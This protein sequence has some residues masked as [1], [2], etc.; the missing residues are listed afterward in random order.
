M[1]NVLH[2]RLVF[3]DICYFTFLVSLMAFSVPWKCRDCN[4]G[5]ISSLYS[6][7]CL[8]CFLVATMPKAQWDRERNMDTI[9]EISLA[10]GEPLFLYSENQ[11][12]PKKQHSCPLCW[13]V[14]SRVTNTHQPVAFKLS[15]KHD[16]LWYIAFRL[17]L[18]AAPIFWH[19]LVSI[20]LYPNTLE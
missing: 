20:T 13:L 6:F 2:F 8:T 4:F 1:D 10:H 11:H 18:L 12:E 19:T 5:G 7:L 16:I 15:Y 9:M 17:F 14:L 3:L